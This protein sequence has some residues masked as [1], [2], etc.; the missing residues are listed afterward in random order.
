MVG[1]RFVD[2]AAAVA[3]DHQR[4]RLAAVEHEVRKH[5]LGA[6]AP[7]SDRRRRPEGGAEIPVAD[8]GADLDRLVLRVAARTRRNGG[9]RDI[10]PQ[11]SKP[12]AGVAA[13]SAT[14]QNQPTIDADIPRHTA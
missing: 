11:R 5:C 14:R 8:A 4:P 7:P 13:E 9:P 2:E 6:V 1:D 10:G 3:A 12:P